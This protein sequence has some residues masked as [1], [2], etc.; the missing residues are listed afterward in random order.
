MA[1]DEAGATLA[2]RGDV[3]EACCHAV[4]YRLVTF[5]TVGLLERFHEAGPLQFDFGSRQTFPWPDIGFLDP[6]ID[7]H[8]S[9][10][11]V[12]GDDLGGIA[13]AFQLR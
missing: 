10:A 12:F 3:D 9:N 5:E 4:N 6:F 2:L 1:D 7:D 8:W 13:C 11:E